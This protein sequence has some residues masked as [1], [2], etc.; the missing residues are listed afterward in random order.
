MT[1][2]IVTSETVQANLQKC[3]SESK[4]SLPALAAVSGVVLGDLCT[5]L[6]RTQC[7]FTV[8]ELMRIMIA[9]GLRSEVLF[10]PTEVAREVQRHTEPGEPDQQGIGGGL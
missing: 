9:L 4:L 3:V 7:H 10:A 8:S 2:S 1:A 5:K 6:T